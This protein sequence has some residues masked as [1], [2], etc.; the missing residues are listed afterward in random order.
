M[1]TPWSISI[2]H[3]HA[4]DSLVEVAGLARHLDG[5][6][7]LVARAVA[8]GAR[9]DGLTTAGELLDHLE[10]L[11]PVERRALLDRARAEVGLES[12]IEID[13]RQQFEALQRTSRRQ[14][15]EI[16]RRPDGSFHEVAP[17]PR[18]G[19]GASGQFVDHDQADADA[20]REATA[21]ESRRRQRQAQ[22]PDRDRDAAEARALAEARATQVRSELPPG[23]PG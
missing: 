2:P 22:Q 1:T 23:V 10:G 9:L 18:F 4:N 3:R 20:A 14:P 19:L 8:L 16:H 13:W 11:E 17:P 21:A 15:T 5:D 6:D 12:T 7:R